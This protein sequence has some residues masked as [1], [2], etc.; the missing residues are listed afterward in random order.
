MG[1]VKDREAWYAVVH[2][3]HRVGHDL[4]TESQQPHIGVCV[5]GGAHK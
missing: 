2:W 4:E 5:W 1:T 3:G